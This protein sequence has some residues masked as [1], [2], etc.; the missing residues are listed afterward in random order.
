MAETY[1]WIEDQKDKSSYVF[2]QTLMNQLCP[3]VILESKK[4]NSE[5]V[6]KVKA[7][8]D[9]E[10]KYII[11][12]DN[13]FD[14]LQVAMEQKMLKRYVDQKENVVLMDI[15]CFEY[16]LL[17]FDEL[18]TWLYAPDDEFW[19]RR[20]KDIHAREKLVDAI[21][22]GNF[23]YKEIKE[24]VAYRE[25]IEKYNIEQLSAKILFQLTRNTGFEISKGTIG[26]CWIKACCEWENRMED[27][28]CG[29]DHKRL[30]LKEKMRHIYEQ[31][32]LKEE[33]Q[34][35]GLEVRF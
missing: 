30:S 20:A 25:H 8:E 13:S 22:T 9:T 19:H 5:L 17:E 27:D 32:C 29:L 28:I 12:F 3:D 24:I 14:N 26:A 4:N 15:I 18:L 33:F 34:K 11:V 2:W 21:K 16:I 10:N 1:L 31:T 23:N 7:L 35:A 6:K